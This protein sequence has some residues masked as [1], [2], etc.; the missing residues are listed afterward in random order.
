MGKATVGVSKEARI[1]AN[2][3]KL[4]CDP[5]HDGCGCVLSAEISSYLESEGY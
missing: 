4:A 5:R 1:I 2:V 3:K